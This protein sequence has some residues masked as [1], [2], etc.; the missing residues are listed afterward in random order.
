MRKALFILGVLLA[1]GGYCSLF[2]NFIIQI[3][4]IMWH[5]KFYTIQYNSILVM[6]IGIYIAYRNRKVGIARRK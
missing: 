3:D 6:L 5:W 4:P 2:L 1:I